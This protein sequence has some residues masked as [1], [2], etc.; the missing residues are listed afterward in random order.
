[1]LLPP[2][3]SVKM[4]GSAHANALRLYEVTQQGLEIGPALTDYTGIITGVA[5]RTPHEHLS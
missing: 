1:M 2:A 5:R 3:S 4:R